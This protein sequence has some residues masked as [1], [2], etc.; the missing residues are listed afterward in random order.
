[1]SPTTLAVL[2]ASVTVVAFL[3][4][5][6]GH[7]GASGCIAGMAP[8]GLSPAFIMPAALALD[9][10]V[11]CLSSRQFCR[12]GHVSWRLLWPFAALGATREA[13]HAETD[14]IG[15]EQAVKTREQR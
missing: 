12:A 11:A 4:P 5:S 15:L 2:S 8:A 1:M 9:I 3:C 7:V 6:V 13:L 14:P 10:L